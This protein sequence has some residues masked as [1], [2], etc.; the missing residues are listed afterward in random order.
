MHA[1]L[2][3]I[4]ASTKTITSIRVMVFINPSM[5]VP[6]THTHSPFPSGGRTLGMAKH[7][8]SGNSHSARMS[9]RKRGT[10]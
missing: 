2:S 1:T 6:K 3:P 7:R 5:L 4:Y 8:F 9:F 10:D